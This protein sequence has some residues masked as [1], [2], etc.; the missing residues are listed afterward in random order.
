MIEKYRQI[1]NKPKLELTKLQ[2]MYKTYEVLRRR[3]SDL[4]DTGNEARVSKALARLKR[5]EEHIKQ[6]QEAR[7]YVDGGEY[8]K[9]GVRV[10]SLVKP[11]GYDSRHYV[12]SSDIQSRL[13]L[14]HSHHYLLSRDC[15]SVTLVKKS[16]QLSDRDLPAPEFARL[17]E[18]DANGVILRIRHGEIYNWR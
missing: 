11:G 18:E 17:N 2:R 15:Q 6:E 3:F 10:F 9:R 16:S 5:L 8:D 14:H 4:K 12:Y 13:T 1:N 7:Y